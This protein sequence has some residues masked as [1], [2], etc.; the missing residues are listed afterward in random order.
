MPN[1]ENPALILAAVIGLILFISLIGSTRHYFSGRHYTGNVVPF[2]RRSRLKL[3]RSLTPGRSVVVWMAAL[4]GVAVFLTS[5]GPDQTDRRTVEGIARVRDVDTVVVQGVPVRLNGVDGPELSTSAG[6]A[7]K[8]W[9]AD[10]LRGKTV[11]CKLN[12]ERTYD[13][14]V[15]VCYVDGEDIG[16]ASIAAGH[17]LDCRRYSGGRYRSLETPEARAR[18]VRAGYC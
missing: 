15:G 16:A 4:I 17:A 8:Q 2:R 10:H 18:I 3:P 11:T 1:I 6:M 12:G 14:W 5:F 9:M 7:A 13:R